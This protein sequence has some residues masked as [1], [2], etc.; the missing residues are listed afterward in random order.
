MLW[1][2]AFRWIEE[3]LEFC[4][5][6]CIAAMNSESVVIE[7]F[8]LQA[9]NQTAFTKKESRTARPANGWHYFERLN[10]ST[11]SSIALMYAAF[12]FSTSDV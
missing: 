8:C 2:T 1:E 12:A 3:R 6:H 11:A 9:K 10:F 5:A 4:Y 7:N